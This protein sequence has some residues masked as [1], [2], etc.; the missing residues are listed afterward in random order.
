MPQCCVDQL[1]SSLWSFFSLALC[2]ACGSLPCQ[3]DAR[4]LADS[5]APQLLSARSE[6][7]PPRSAAAQS[8]TLPGQHDA[9]VGACETISANQ[10]SCWLVC[11]IPGASLTRLF[12][13]EWRGRKQ[14]VRCRKNAREAGRTRNSE[15]RA[16][17]LT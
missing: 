4:G 12:R 1:R 13:V 3:L 17:H 9:F 8:E 2:C 7:P 14:W 11:L 5:R 6:A 16:A 10:V 15:Q